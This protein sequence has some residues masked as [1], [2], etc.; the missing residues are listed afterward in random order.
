MAGY[1]KDK[2]AGLQKGF[3]ESGGGADPLVNAAGSAW[4]YLT[5]QSD[6]SDDEDAKKKQKLKDNSGY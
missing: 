6:S 1:N 4:K 3:Q 2:M 5:G